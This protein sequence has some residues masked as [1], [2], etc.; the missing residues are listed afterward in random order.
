MDNN[1]N[2][3]QLK[4][5]QFNIQSLNNKKPLL[6]KFLQ[7]KNLDICL[8]NETWFKENQHISIP[9]YNLHFKNAKNEH[10][11]VAILIRPYFK[12]KLIN[13]V[14]YE[15]IQ[16][17]AISISTGC[18]ELT[19][20]CVYCPPTSSHIRINKL[21]NLIR[22]LPK[23]I[24]VSG[25]FNAHH[26]AF[27]CLSTKGRGQQLYNVIDELDLCIL[28]DGNFTT[29]NYPNR[30]PSAIDVAFT[31]S[32]IA[33]LCDWTVHDDNMGSY[34]FPVIITIA[35]SI[36]RYQINPPID[37]FMY[38]K[39][40]WQKYHELS[41]S[42]FTNFTINSDNPLET[43]EYFCNKLNSLKEECVRKF[44]KPSSYKSKLPAPW[45]NDRCEKSVTDSYEALKY[46]RSNPTI[47]NFVKYQRLNA[48]KKRT[49]SEEKKNGWSRL[50]NSFNR[51]TPISKIW[52]YIKMFKHRKA[53]NKSYSDEF[54]DGFFD[55][56]TETGL[57]IH[58]LNTYFD[59]HNS[60][61]KSSFLI[62]KFTFHEFENSLNSRKNT[63]PGLDDFPYILIKKLDTSVQKLFLNILNSLWVNQIIPQ[64]WKTQCVIPVLKQDKPPEDPNSY[65]PISL[66]SCL[67]KIFEN[68]IKTRLDWFV[69]SNGLIP[70]VQYGFRKGRSCAD[71]FVSLISDLIQLSIKHL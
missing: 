20:L 27:G 22:Y 25:D 55:K 21:R 7:E 58:E 32:A 61:I 45:W 43:Y 16:T 64:S 18:G 52:N 29:I 38:S 2:I 28:N 57:H 23:P 3:T 53:S 47:G 9:G 11:G 48:I 69:E 65:R 37:K 63:S 44:T 68:M 46:Y 19:L 71:S 67:G 33:P 51:T 6:I 1:L 60:D 17:I 39:A 30:N 10:G 24:L 70:N 40:N 13:T 42:F 4:I 15:D 41:K 62:Q 14:F 66:S 31:S 12:Y 36:D 59:L 35:L 56:L 26:I 34:H 49:I 54:I 50:C 5:A 8:L